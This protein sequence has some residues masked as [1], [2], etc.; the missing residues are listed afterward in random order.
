MLFVLLK[1]HLAVN[2]SI[3]FLL[4]KKIDFR[5]YPT[6]DIFSVMARLHSYF[7]DVSF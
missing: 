4:S 3:M 2:N 6:P 5:S 1:F 7:D